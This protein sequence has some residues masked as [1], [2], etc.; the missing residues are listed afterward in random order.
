MKTRTLA[1]AHL[2]TCLLLIL[3][4]AL[5]LEPA[6]AAP[7]T[8]D[9]GNHI[10]LT[11]L[12]NGQKA[13]L[14]FDTGAE[15]SVLFRKSAERL[16]VKTI[17]RVPG[18][19]PTN[20][21]PGRVRVETSEPFLITMGD[22]N[23]ETSF[24][25]LD[26]ASPIGFDGIISWNHFQYK[27]LKID[28]P[29]GAVSFLEKLPDGAEQWP[30][31]KLVD[32]SKQNLG[33]KWLGFVVP[34]P[35]DR[36]GAVYID[37]G[38]DAG[39]SLSQGQLD[40]WKTNNPHPAGTMDADYYPGLQDG[41]VI[42][43][44]FWATNLHLADG[45]TFSNVAISL[46][47][48]SEAFIPNYEARLGMFAIS[49]LEIIVDGQNRVIYIRPAEGRT[50]SLYYNYNRIGAVFTPQHLSGGDLTAHVFKGSPAYEAGLRDGDVLLNIGSLD[51]TR[52][53]TDPRILPLGR[54][55]SQPAGTTINLK[56]RRG[57]ETLRFTITL[58]EIFP[59]EPTPNQ[60]STLD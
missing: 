32:R 47:P 58:K 1:S 12:I 5:W 27:V 24:K 30:H 23:V 8:N 15:S 38:A 29:K 22:A 52:W 4:C 17:A 31:W 13:R 6:H 54:F 19:T 36:P 10:M 40:A 33:S 51:A 28:G 49:Q 37:T 14:A 20:T 21:V 56:C 3:L 44:V 2:A 25:I 7:S 50:N 35:N 26:T 34:A 46:C 45:L 39:I 53:T 59:Q 57:E 42:R 16:G 48:P 18:Q 43:E 11:V 9:T 55:W 60:G 41:L